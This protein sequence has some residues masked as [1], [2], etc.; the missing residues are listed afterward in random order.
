MN[1]PVYRTN[2]QSGIYRGGSEF[3]GTVV[4]GN[5]YEEDV[6]GVMYIS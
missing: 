2:N 1:S 6:D 3:Y 4:K 5:R